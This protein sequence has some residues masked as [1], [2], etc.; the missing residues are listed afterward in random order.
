MEASEVLLALQVCS[1]ALPI[2][3]LSLPELVK[4]SK[5]F[6]FVFEK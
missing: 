6:F 5:P 1:D 3:A 4:A 2:T